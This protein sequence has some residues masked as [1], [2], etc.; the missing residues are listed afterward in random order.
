MGETES[1]HNAAEVSKTGHKRGAPVA[2]ATSELS[3]QQT[4]D[5]ITQQL[6]VA[7]EGRFDIRV[8]APQRDDSTTKLLALINY[9][10]SAADQAVSHLHEQTAL[11]L[12][13][14]HEL[15]AANTALRCSQEFLQ[16]ALDA[17]GAQVAVLDVSGRIV[18]VNQSWLQFAEANGY[19]GGSFTAGVNYLDV[20]R[21]AAAHGSKDARAT[22]DGIVAVAEGRDEAFYLEYACPSPQEARWFQMRVNRFMVG[23]EP[24]I[25]VAHENISEL[26]RA[27]IARQDSEEKFGALVANLPGAVYRRK[28]D[29]EWTADYLSSYIFN[30]AGYPASDFIANRVR[31][32][33]SII[34]AEDMLYV[35]TA[36]QAALATHAPFTVDYRILHA[37]GE[38]RW[39]REFGQ[40]FFGPGGALQHMDGLILDISS[41]KLVEE[42]LHRY[43][44]ELEARVAAR[45]DELVAAQRQLMQAE[46]LASI[47]QLAAGIAHEINTPIQFVGDN[48]NTLAD[49]FHTLLELIEKY[50][51][52]AAP[53]PEE[54]TASLQAAEEEAD[55]AFLLEDTPKAIE[56]SLDGVHR[57][58]H[59]VRA[60]K[61]FSHV[62]REQLANIDL[63]ALI[64]STLTVCR[65][66]YKYVADVV[67]DFADLPQV[68]C[69]ASDMSQVLLN[70]IVNA[71]HAIMDTKKRGTIHITTRV[72]EEAV[73]ILI[74]DT[75]GGIPEAIR[76]RIFDPF[77][78]T[79]A[80]G[81]G[82]GQ[83]LH[84]VY[85]TIVHKHG[86]RIDFTSKVGE[87]TTFNVFVPIQCKEP[88]ADEHHA[89]KEV[90]P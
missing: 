66:E 5:G 15:H 42:E 16:G 6:Y 41:V 3:L 65:N 10:L 45:S 81:R 1:Q 18:S 14:E 83:G 86:G 7:I 40:G 23:D 30:I 64:C 72:V 39:V 74:A 50:R 27:E 47:G 43:R 62:G 21:R 69:Y 76:S 48:L 36:V 56:Q 90:V 63:N 59:I 70:L 25:R 61:D 49:T 33:A 34:S 11:L 60:M 55:L 73:E 87:G 12:G 9:I 22:Y 46:K 4:I 17:A 19:R 75:G 37:D 28:A 52:A 24:F 38:Q 71:A 35:E 13:R 26:R 78:T 67:T 32:F 68:E 58:A 53:L 77:F 51:A 84:I 79:K 44:A 85:Q 31:S 20:C 54:P 29:A 88:P 57:V 8:T 82:T 89:V 2:N 80:V